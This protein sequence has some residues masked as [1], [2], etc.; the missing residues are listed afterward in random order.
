[1][2]DDRL[3]V[4]IGRQMC[5]KR[6]ANGARLAVPCF[7]NFEAEKQPRSGTRGRP[8]GRRS[9]AQMGKREGNI[10]QRRRAEESISGLGDWAELGVPRMGPISSSGNAGKRVEK[11]QRSSRASAW[12]NRTADVWGTRA[13]VLDKFGTS[14]KVSIWNR[15]E[16]ERFLLCGSC[17][18]VGKAF[19]LVGGRG[20]RL[21][22]HSQRLK[23]SFAS[24][25]QQKGAEGKTQSN[26]ARHVHSGTSHPEFAG[27]ERRRLAANRKR[28][29]KHDAEKT[30]AR[31]HFGVLFP[32]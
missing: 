1:M 6:E 24:L 17:G 19:A 20:Q 8:T 21:K 2:R 16:S 31:C 27:K 23:N 4:G 13:A 3:E 5:T 28:R 25:T 22:S 29:I 26:T 15:G 12:E 30:A 14:R 10:G 11:R 9:Q 7:G 18:I 32:G